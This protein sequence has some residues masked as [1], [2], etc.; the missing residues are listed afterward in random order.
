MAVRVKRNYVN[1]KDFYDALVAYI[2]K[3]KEFAEAGKPV[4]KIPDYIGECIY[5][6]AKR[7]ATK[8]CFVNYS[9]KEDMI[10]DGI[11]NSILYMHNYNPEKS[12]NPFAYFTRIIWNAFIQRIKKEKKE[13]YIKYKSYENAVLMG[14]GE[15]AGSGGSTEININ[16]NMTAFVNDY[17]RKLAE[18]KIP[19]KKKGV[20]VFVE[21]EDGKD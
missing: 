11:E 6:I 5:H 1:N 19:S 15:E 13:T 12:T 18:K 14:F 10:S 9:F 16:D 20:E 8:G 7:L 4:P 21:D 17:E 2:S 3:K